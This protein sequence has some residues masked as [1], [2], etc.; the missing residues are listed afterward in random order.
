[1]M[2]NCIRMTTGKFG[3]HFDLS[4]PT[5]LIMNVLDYNCTKMQQFKVV[6]KNMIFYVSK[7]ISYF[8]CWLEENNIFCKK[9]ISKIQYQK[10]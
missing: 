8:S 3:M 9:D 6:R 10:F 1:M 4:M 7:T 2:E 5:E